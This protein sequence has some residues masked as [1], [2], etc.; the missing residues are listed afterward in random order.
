M[1]AMMAGLR[2][3]ASAAG[4]ARID[5]LDMLRGLA[6]LGIL[7]INVPYMAASGRQIRSYD[8]RLIGWTRDR[9]K[10]GMGGAISRSGRARSA[11]C[12]NS[13]SVPA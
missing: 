11:A 5:V 9:I 12:C 13:C 6:I 1:A 3:G 2:I 4:E 7:F 10:I 8:P